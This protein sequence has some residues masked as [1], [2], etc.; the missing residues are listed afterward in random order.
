MSFK[1]IVSDRRQD[2]STTTATNI[3][4]GESVVIPKDG[5]P[6]NLLADGMN[7]IC[8]DIKNIDGE[9]LH[10]GDLEVGA[11]FELSFDGAFFNLQEASYIKN[12]HKKI[13]PQKPHS[14]FI[15]AQNRRKWKS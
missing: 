14:H 9:P 7:H 8:I 2:R 1:D 12:Q 3:H 11:R 15:E 4:T 10:C 5:A 6:V 13:H